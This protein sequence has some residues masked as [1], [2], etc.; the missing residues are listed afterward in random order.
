MHPSGF[1]GFTFFVYLVSKEGDAMMQDNN[2]WNEP[3]IYLQ[4]GLKQGSGAALCVSL[5]YCSMIFQLSSRYASSRVR[6]SKYASDLQ[7]MKIRLPLS[8]NRESA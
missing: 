6:T 4:K 8:Y 3:Q 5:E 7:N 2:T 1:Y